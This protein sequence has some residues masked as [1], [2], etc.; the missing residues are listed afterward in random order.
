MHIAY[1][2]KLDPVLCTTEEYEELLRTEKW[3]DCPKKAKEYVE[4]VEKVVEAVEVVEAKPV[5]KNKK[6]SK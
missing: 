2:K 5:A 6:K 4:V 3:F 1:H